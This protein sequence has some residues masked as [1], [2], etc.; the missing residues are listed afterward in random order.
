MLESELL[1]LQEVPE[2]LKLQLFDVGGVFTAPSRE[3]SRFQE[4]CSSASVAALLFGG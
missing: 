4:D 1:S 2:V 3:R